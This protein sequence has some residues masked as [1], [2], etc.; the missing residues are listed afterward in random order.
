MRD[1]EGEMQ[2]SDLDLVMAA[3][4]EIMADRNVIHYNYKKL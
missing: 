1:R 3:K 4:I 2:Y